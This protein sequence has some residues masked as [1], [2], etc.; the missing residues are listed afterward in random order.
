[1]GLPRVVDRGWDLSLATVSWRRPRL[2][3]LARGRRWLDPGRFGP[4][5]A[6]RV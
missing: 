3:T 5:A 4:I 6:G 2:T 1:M